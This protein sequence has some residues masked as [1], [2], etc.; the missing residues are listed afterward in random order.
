MSYGLN[1]EMHKQV[2]FTT[3]PFRKVSSLNNIV[4]PREINTQTVRAFFFLLCL[5]T[6]L[7]HPFALFEAPHRLSP[8]A[9][10][11]ESLKRDISLSHVHG[12]INICLAITPPRTHAAFT[13]FDPLCQ[14]AISGERRGAFDESTDLYRVYFSF[15]YKF[16]S[17]R[18]PTKA[19]FK[20][21]VISTNKFDCNQAFENINVALESF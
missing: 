7:C 10:L 14:L 17:I 8:V 2:N 4:S 3:T 18:L 11:P 19:T 13:I 12:R 21:F 16:F 5:A 6:S 15:L 9:C 20:R 1:V